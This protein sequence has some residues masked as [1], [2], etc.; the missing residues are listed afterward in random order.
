MDGL[1]LFSWGALSVVVG[2]FASS[3]GRNGVF[4]GGASLLFSPL[5]TGIVLSLMVATG[6][7]RV[8]EAG[9]G[10][11]G[12]KNFDPDEHEKKCPDCAEYIKLEARV[13]RYCGYEFSDEEVEQQ[14]AQVRSGFRNTKQKPEREEPQRDP[15]FSREV[16]VIVLGGLALLSVLMVLLVLVVS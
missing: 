3:D 13:C 6:S 10:A 1:T 8:V 12:N 15:V 11:L 16:K 9:S 2:L 14:I 4:W 5:I 7:D